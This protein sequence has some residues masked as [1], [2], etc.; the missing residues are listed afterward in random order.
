MT[1]QQLIDAGAL[2]FC[3]HSGGKD[4]QAMYC[5][6]RLIIPH[7]QIV[8][9]H[10]NLGEV[11]WTGVV[12]H[13]KANIDHPLNV[14]TA[15][16]MDGSEKTLLGMVEKRHAKFQANIERINNGGVIYDANIPKLA[17]PW[18]STAMR[19]CTSDL[20]RDPIHKFIRNECT[21]RGATLA[22][23]CTGI[24]AEEST[25]R[26]KLVEFEPCKRLCNT[27]RTVY[28]WRPI[29][30]LTTAEVFTAIRAAGQRPFWAYADG[31]ERLSCVFCI[32]GS[33]SD[34]AHGAERRPELYAKYLE[35]EQ[36]TG[37]TMFHDKS[38]ADRMIVR[39]NAA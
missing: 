12:E 10:A 20:K 19:Y 13:I 28:E 17:A 33:P 15:Q 29:H 8:V 30:R 25:A 34:L 6:L 11:E 4:S 32:M 24:R 37:Y 26:S 14:V 22:V 3:S 1:I 18:P 27:K 9:I 5:L 35:M 31:N 23:N 7:D 2:F 21:R 38:L 16:W 36:R 39:S